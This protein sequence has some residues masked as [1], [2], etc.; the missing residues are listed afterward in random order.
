MSAVEISPS[1]R[2]GLDMVAINGA[3]H[4]SETLSKW[5]GREVR[6]ETDGFVSVPLERISELMRSAEELVVAVHTRIEGAM[7]G[8]VLLAF[9]EKVAFGLVDVLL[10]QTPGT[11]TELEE[12][13]QSAI[14]ETANIVASA[15]INSL[16]AAL[17]VRATPGV[18][19][20]QHDMG[21]AIIEPLVMEQ[22]AVSD[23]ALM[24]SAVFEIDALALDWW[25]FVLPSPESVPVMEALLA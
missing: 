8:H 15:F 24:I 23:R 18:P 2:A 19:T 14:Q 4:A 16:S 11:T 7:G 20:C 10:G 1:K 12:M 25:L 17:G 21:G 6:I 22:L 3:T 9:P 13:G 5:F